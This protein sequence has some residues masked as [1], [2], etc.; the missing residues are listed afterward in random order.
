[1][2]PLAL[3]VLGSGLVDPDTP[4]LTAD[5]AALTRGQAAFET[6]RVYGGKAFAL[7]EHL[8]RLEAS[9]ARLELPA[10]AR[11]ALVELAAMALAAAGTAECALRF[12]WTGGRDGARQAT[13]MA[14]VS[15]LPPGLEELQARGIRVIAL[16]LG[17]D[18]HARA[19]SP[20]LLAGVKST[21]YAVNLAARA[22][23]VRRGADDALFLATDGTVLE[24]PTS[25]VWWRYGDV[26]ETPSLDVGVLAGVTRSRILDLA[27]EAGYSVDAGAWPLPRLLA[28]DEV[29]MSSSLREIV[30]VIEVDGQAVADGR[31]GVAAATLQ[32]GLRRA[33][34]A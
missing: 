34:T 23:A 18:T 11:S 29:L 14:M 12:Y 22:E 15:A 13:A 21:S 1:M 19:G 5:D 10:V 30:S 32:A 4:V 8:D 24:G 28:A 3:A 31:P 17:I 27:P 2:K 25:N 16:D 20:W 7:D 33:A 9:A 6:L 26:L